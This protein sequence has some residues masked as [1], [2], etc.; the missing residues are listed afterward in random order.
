ME[1]PSNILKEVKVGLGKTAFEKESVNVFIEELSM[2]IEDAKSRAEFAEKQLAETKRTLQ[3]LEEK[4][5]LEGI[6][7][8]TV[9]QLRKELTVAKENASSAEARAMQAEQKYQQAQEKVISLTEECEK[10]NLYLAG[11]TKEE[12]ADKGNFSIKQTMA[13]MEA[14]NERLREALAQKSDSFDASFFKTESKELERLRKELEEKNIIIKEHD[15][16]LAESAVQLTSKTNE[17]IALQA[18]NER[19]RDELEAAAQNSSDTSSDEDTEYLKG[20]VSKQAELLETLKSNYAESQKAYEEMESKATELEAKVKEQDTSLQ[21]KTEVISGLNHKVEELEQT[22]QELKLNGTISN[23]IEL[24]VS[25]LYAEAQQT[26]KQWLKS[27]KDKAAILTANAE[28]KAKEMAEEAEKH[29][30]SVLSAATE[31]AERI[32]SKAE[33]EA[34]VLLRDAGQY[35][36]HL[37]HVMDEVRN[38]IAEKLREAAGF[39]EES[40]G[41]FNSASETFFA[42]MKKTSDEDI[43]DTEDTEAEESFDE[44]TTEETDTAIVDENPVAEEPWNDEDEE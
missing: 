13:E 20:L 28:Q 24:D 27:A 18:E 15:E 43:E 41:R 38:T 22:I 40:A 17:V 12:I 25:D 9:N 14:E 10:Y 31:E 21:D 26:A 30:E 32:H 29:K 19:L 4:K 35:M 23:D 7:E 42:G 44:N 3:E 34:D 37:N 39:A 2:Q 8:D 6:S 5:A 11:A 16:S 36:H 33:Q 1:V